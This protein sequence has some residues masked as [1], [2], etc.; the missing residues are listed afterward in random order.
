M[1][2]LALGEILEK[3]EEEQ[4]MSDGRPSV[5][6]TDSRHAPRAMEMAGMVYDGEISLAEVGFCKLE[7]QQECLAGSL[8]IPKLLDV[9]GSRYRMLFFINQHHIVIVDDDDFAKRL[10]IRIR[11]SKTNQG[12]TRERFLYNFIGQFMSRDLELLGRYERLIMGMEER[13]ADGKTEGFQS[14]IS[15]IRRELLTLRGY[16]DELMDMGKELEEN[17]NGFFARKQLKYFGTIADRADRLMGRTGYLLEYA[18]QVRDTYQAQVDAVQNKNMQFLTVVS[19]IF[20]PL[21]LITGWYGMNFQNMPELKHGY[22]GVI[23]LSLI[24]VAVCIIFFKKKKIL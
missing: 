10:I 19:T 5:L 7:T 4:V 14:K 24:V 16:Y 12:D 23:L 2:I 21:T 15:P 22:P 3:I 20:F 6:I 18:Q 8:C 11:R 17:E 9:L 13:V 1:I